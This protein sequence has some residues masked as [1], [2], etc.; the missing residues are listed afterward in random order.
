MRTALLLVG[1]A[2]L[3]AGAR[4]VSNAERVETLKRASVR[5]AVDPSA[6][7][8]RNGPAEPGLYKS[9]EAV[10]CR[11]EEKD[12]KNP[13]G[14]HS[15]K[16]PCWTP[17]G[18]RL[19][20]KYGGGENPEIFG[21]V[22]AA[23]LFW[24]LGFHAD[25]M[26]SVK[27]VCDNCPADPWTSTAQSP[28]ATRAFEPVSLQ[29]RLPGA[30]VSETEGEGWTFD[31]LAEMDPA[32]GGA[33]RAE[34]D[35]LKLLAV[36][37]NHGDNTANQQRL[38]C[39]PGDDACRR[40]LA[41]VTDLG[42]TFGGKG[43]HTSYKNWAKRANIWKDAKTCVADYQGTLERFKDPAISEEG[44]RLLADLLGK[45]SEAQVRDLFSGARFDLLGKLDTPIIDAAGRSRPATVDDWTALFLKKREQILSARC[46]Q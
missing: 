31:E 44:R 14:G 43:N 35:A 29:R 10:A 40:P 41:Y 21:E 37:V 30:E 13:L 16:F 1:L 11:Y 8:L 24:A 17:A 18:E 39:P 33:T 20:V 25:R 38:L 3:P 26:S 12:P 22:A 28:R 34:T 4:V 27:I 42:G 5:V 15:K 2:S 7:D 32:L 45:L 23:R 9:G 6:M 19:K 36:F 46:P